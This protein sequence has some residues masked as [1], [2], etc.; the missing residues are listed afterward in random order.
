MKQ[1]YLYKCNKKKT[2]ASMWSFNHN[3]KKNLD[4]AQSKQHEMNILTTS[5]V[6]RA[7]SCC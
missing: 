2:V 6:S 1:Q 5:R 4:I 7:V 3:A